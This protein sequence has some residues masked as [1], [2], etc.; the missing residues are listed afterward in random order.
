MS[1]WPELSGQQHARRYL[2]AAIITLLAS[3]SNLV[4]MHRLFTD[5]NFRAS[6]L[7]ALA[8]PSVLQFWQ[9]QYEDL[10]PAARLQRIEPLLGRLES[11]FMGRSLVRNVLGQ[12]NTIDFRRAIMNSEILLF[13]LGVNTLGQDAYLIGNMIISQVH[14]AVFS[15]ANLLPANRPSFSFYIDEARHFAGLPELA[16]MLTDGRKYCIR[17]ALAFQHRSQLPAS[18]QEPTM[19]ARTKICFQSTPDDAREL[20]SLFIGG[21]HV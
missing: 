9:T 16:S 17:L 13:K 14:A 21:T 6:K 1:H 12:E 3:P 11:L 2:Q 18:L 15:F 19:N 10:A 20:A 4:D 5:N 8:D 7:R